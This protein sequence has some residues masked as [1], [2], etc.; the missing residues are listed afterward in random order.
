LRRSRWQAARVYLNTDVERAVRLL[1]EAVTITDG[2]V[3]GAEREAQ[4]DAT[5]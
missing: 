5:R 4:I 1:R 3:A 2:A